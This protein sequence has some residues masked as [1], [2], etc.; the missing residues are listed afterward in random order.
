MKARAIL[1]VL[2]L[3]P[4]VVPR[5]LR[6]NLLGMALV[7]SGCAAQGGG[8]PSSETTAAASDPSGAA[9]AEQAPSITPSQL[10]P[11]GSASAAAPTVKFPDNDQAE[12][13]P[14]SKGAPAALYAELFQ[15]GVSWT[16]KV[17]TTSGHYDD[18]PVTKV[19]NAKG[20]CSVV[21]SETKPWAVVSFIACDEVG[22]P[23]TPALHGWW[24]ATAKGLYKAEGERDKLNADVLASA[25]L[26]IRAAPSISKVKHEDKENEGFG[27]NEEI[28]NKGGMWCFSTESW[29]G[30]EG[31]EKN[32]WEEG[33]GFVEGKW[34]WAGGSSHE[35]EYS[36]VKN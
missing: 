16:V 14:T 31:W 4:S 10:A 15:K 13:A 6:T 5:R 17:K 25:R 35:N 20:K 23:P 27:Y 28:T 2:R 9:S 29:G 26:T 12:A 1:P 19:T 3:V 8:V 36:A 30:D 7:A 18:K 21:E 33:K 32:C 11:T 24:F 22:D 34:G